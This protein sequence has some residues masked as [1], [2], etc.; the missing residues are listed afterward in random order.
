[1]AL[2]GGLPALL[3]QFAHERPPESGF[4]GSTLGLVSHL[5][6]TVSG[7]QGPMVVDRLWMSGGPAV[8]PSAL[9]L[10]LYLRGWGPIERGSEMVVIVAGEESERQQAEIPGTILLSGHGYTVSHVAEM[11][12]FE[13]SQKLCGHGYRM[14]GAWDA[15]SILQPATTTES[16]GSW[17]ACP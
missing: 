15:L 4:R 8:E 9:M 10:D 16:A 2:M 1:M 3:A 7:L 17:W 14:G 12:V 11:A 5:G 6:R 13:W